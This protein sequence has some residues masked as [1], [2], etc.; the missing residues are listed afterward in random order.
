[1]IM[2]AFIGITFMCH[3]AI[4]LIEHLFFMLIYKHNLN[5][6]PGDAY[7]KGKLLVMEKMKLQREIHEFMLVPHL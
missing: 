6:L 2:M 4:L 1:M 7:L 3:V 5:W